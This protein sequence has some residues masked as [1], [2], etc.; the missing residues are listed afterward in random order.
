MTRHLPP[1]VPK[2]KARLEKLKQFKIP[3]TLNNGDFA[4]RNFGFKKAEKMSEDSTEDG[5]ETMVLFDWERAFISHP[6]FD[7]RDYPDLSLLREYLSQ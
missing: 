7:I 4:T 3:L 5:K 1:I 2:L 6:F